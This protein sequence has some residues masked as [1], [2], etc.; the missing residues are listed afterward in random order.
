MK[1]FL[2][3]FFCFFVLTISLWSEAVDVC[4]VTL[5]PSSVEH[6]VKLTKV[7]DQEKIS[8]QIV[9]ADISEQRLKERKIP[10]HKISVWTSKKTISE[11]SYKEKIAIAKLT[12]KTCKKA[13]VIITDISESFIAEVHHELSLVSSAKRYVYYDNPEAYVPGEYS[14][15]FEEVV[16]TRPYGVVFA[17]KNLSEE[18]LYGN[19]KE[20][21]DID[22][23]DKLGLGLA[24]M[25]DVEQLDA[26]ADNKSELRHKLFEKLGI[27]D[28]KQKLLVYLGGSNS[29][30][31]SH[32][33]P[34]FLRSIEDNLSY[35]FFDNVL[36]LLQQHPRAKQEG[37]MDLYELLARGFPFQVFLSPMSTLEMMTC[38]DLIYYYQSSLAPKLVLAKRPLV[39]VTP[40]PLE[41]MSTRL[42]LVNSVMHPKDFISNSLI[43]LSTNYQ[44]Q[45]LKLLQDN[46]GYDENWESTFAAFIKR[47]L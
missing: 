32:A 43:A 44:E 45:S 8:W 22:P 3:I 34:F 28:E 42:H 31:F 13:K 11:L 2:S 38:A 46:L 10:H 5:H 17:N 25:E 29:M 16:K 33:F 24:L 21:L 39:Q 18:T 7:L 9:A 37:S 26:L 47:V 14:K 36:L 12:A 20:P 35:P 23:F 27:Q 6:F 30:Y 1:V 4:F 19:A 40:E 15:V 41:D